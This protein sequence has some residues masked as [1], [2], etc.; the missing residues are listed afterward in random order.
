MKETKTEVLYSDTHKWHVLYD[1]HMVLRA[2]SSRERAETLAADIEAHGGKLP[3]KC[4]RTNE[5]DLRRKG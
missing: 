5:T 4:K 1:G 2:Q 3:P